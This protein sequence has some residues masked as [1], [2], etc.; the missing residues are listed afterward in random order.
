MTGIF[1]Y[2]D[3]GGGLV[4]VGELHSSVRRGRVSSSFRYDTDFVEQRRAYAIEPAL[5]LST[6]SW[7]LGRALPRSF[8]D[9]APD[10]WGRNL[11]AKR[12]RADAAVA[13]LAARQLDERDY[14]LGVSDVTRQGALRFSTEPGGEFQHASAEVP[15]LLALPRLLRAADRVSQ[16]D[17]GS[18]SAIKELLDA[19]TGSL[20]GARPKASVGDGDRLLIAKFPHHADHWDVMGWEK[21]AL[22]L[23]EAAGVTVPHT[24]LIDIDG[25]SVLLLERF[26]RSGSD[27]I[28]YISAMTLLES[29]DGE[30]RDYLE[31]AEAM[32]EHGS[33]TTSDLRQLWRRIAFSIAIHNTDD[34]LRNHGFLRRDAGWTLAPAFDLN[35]HPE[36][37]ATRVT[38]V[39]GAASPAEELDA[40]LTSA[41]MFDV[42]QDAARRVLAEVGAAAA[43]WPDV[44][45]SNGVPSRD[46]E[47][48]RPTLDLTT[49][50]VK[51]AAIR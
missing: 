16:D 14:L 3:I 1:A 4:A 50:L 35:P 13:G 32:A 45:R 20:G 21:T 10:R 12:A 37:G 17:A 26:D 38:S 28:G 18:L 5:P 27:R 47:R 25:R 30:G 36:L 51:A 9:A 15:K 19:G 11:I 6:G 48:F 23:A 8:D 7:P 42:T 46:V 49:E 43:G 34:H 40:L 2:T 31:I 44:A 41:A 24:Q 29:D 39:G 33:H 22:D